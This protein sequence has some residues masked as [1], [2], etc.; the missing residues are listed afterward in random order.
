MY[1]FKVS[2]CSV[3]NVCYVATMYINLFQCVY[4]ACVSRFMF[5]YDYDVCAINTSHKK[6]IKE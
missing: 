6:L 1:V 4:Y 3:F 5:I 2:V